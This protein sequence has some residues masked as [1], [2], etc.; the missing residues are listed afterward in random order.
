MKSGLAEGDEVV[1]LINALMDAINNGL[2]KGTLS[3]LEILEAGTSL[4]S[5]TLDKADW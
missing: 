4:M 3:K 2:A 1:P 5:M